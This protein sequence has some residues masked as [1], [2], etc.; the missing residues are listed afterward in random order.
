MRWFIALALVV[1]CSKNNDPPP[2]SSGVPGAKPESGPRSG[3][4]PGVA[5]SGDERAHAMFETIC[6]TCHGNSGLGNGPAAESLP[7]KPRNY[8]DAVWQAN[9]TDAQIKD[10]IV[11]GGQAVGKSPLMPANPELEKDPDKLEGLVKIIR[12]FG[13]K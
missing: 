7:T 6:A 1:A 2:P 5:K 8:T 9:V 12:A 11:H 3:G 4:P 10:I 13:K